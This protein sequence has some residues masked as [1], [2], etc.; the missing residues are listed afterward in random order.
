MD[1]RIQA[2]VSWIG[3]LLVLLVVGTGL[4]FSQSPQL[5]SE[6]AVAVRLVDEAWH[7]L[8]VATPDVWPAWKTYRDEVYFA[9]IPRVQDILINPPADPGAAYVRL[10]QTVQDT[11]VYLR[12]P[13]PIERVWGGAYR[14]RLGD[15]RI[16]AVQ[17]YAPSPEHAQR[18]IKD[19]EGRASPNA[20][21]SSALRVLSSLEYL[22]STIIHEAFH[23]YQGSAFD[24]MKMLN[25][26]HPS[27]FDG[28]ETQA[29]LSRLE[30][31]ILW[32]A[33]AVRDRDE[34]VELSREFLAV[35]WA[36]RRSLT[37]EDIA[38]ER[39]NE[40]VEGTA[41]YAETRVLQVVAERGYRPK[42]LESSEAN[43][44]GFAIASEMVD[45]NVQWVALSAHG[46]G[47]DG[48]LMR[49]YYAGMAQGMILDRLVGPDWKNSILGPEV[50]VENLLEKASGF[51]AKDAPVY[52]KKAQ[53][54][55]RY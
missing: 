3:L 9:A 28:G 35:R 32:R 37:P 2:S 12:D 55:F 44:H 20:L 21:P 30:G 4:S 33:V 1:Q 19:A 54:R 52:L 23:Q 16:E 40:L 53:E 14:F 17:F 39:R 6:L 13:S 7:I 15:R 47:E 46:R 31:Q 50:Y 43:F 22:I 18:W 5:R 34:L 45:L 24:R 51:D 29:S 26:T 42:V 48:A 27:P 10:Q 11:P 41:T 36:R 8:D 49:C 25:K 38:W